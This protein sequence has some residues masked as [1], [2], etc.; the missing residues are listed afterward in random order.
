MGLW[1]LKIAFT[2][3]GREFVTLNAV[4]YTLPNAVWSVEITNHQKGMLA[5]K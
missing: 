5:N 3:P 2:K 4:N 1:L